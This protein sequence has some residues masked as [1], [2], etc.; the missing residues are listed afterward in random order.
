[1]LVAGLASDQAKLLRWRSERFTLPATLLSEP[2]AAE[3]LRSLL[4]QAEEIFHRVRGIAAEMVAETLADP[5]NKDTR[6]RA[7]DMVHAGPC[8]AAFFSTA[9][10]ALPGL[11]GQIDPFGA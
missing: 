1:M 3:F 10:R 5:G 6:S 11:L 8:E 9:E 4:R 2:E 7:R